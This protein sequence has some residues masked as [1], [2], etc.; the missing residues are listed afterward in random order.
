YLSRR[1]HVFDTAVGTAADKGRVYPCDGELADPYRVMWF[2]R[3]SHHRYEGADVNICCYCVGGI[4]VSVDRFKRCAS[5][6]TA[7]PDNCRR[8]REENYDCSHLCCHGGYGDP[9]IKRHPF[10]CITI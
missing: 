2:A 4:R 3:P 7:I 10:H 8:W 5:A 9:F 6:S 1:S